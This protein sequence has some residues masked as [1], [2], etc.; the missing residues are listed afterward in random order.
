MV[1]QES[2]NEYFR[3]RLIRDEYGID[4]I[5]N[6]NPLGT[7]VTNRSHGVSILL[8]YSQTHQMMTVKEIAEG[9]KLTLSS[10]NIPQNKYRIIYDGFLKQLCRLFHERNLLVNP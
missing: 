9:I 10:F 8:N 5:T 4:Y 1:L 3:C 6:E 2:G 7:E